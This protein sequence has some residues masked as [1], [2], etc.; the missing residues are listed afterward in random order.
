VLK[1]SD[2]KDIYQLSPLQKGMLFHYLHDEGQ[3]AYFEQ[4]DFTIEGHIDTACLEES[5]NLLIQKYDIFR[6]V[7]LY[8]K[9]NEPVQVVLKERKASVHFIDVSHMED[10]EA[11]IEQFKVKD[12]ET[13]FDLSSDLL[14]R[15][16]V[17]KTDSEQYH[18]IWSFHHILMDGWCLGIVL[19]DLFTMYQKK[20]HQEPVRLEAVTPY[21]EY[22]RWLGKQNTKLAQQYWADYLAGFDQLSDIPFREGKAQQYRYVQQELVY[23]LN[24]SVTSRLDQLAKK[25]Q[26]TLNTVFR[27]IWGI[28][29][30]RYN[31]STDAVFGTIVSGRPSEVRDVENIVGLFI[32]TIPVRVQCNPEEHFLQLLQKLQQASSESD[33]YSY[34]SL[35]DIQHGNSGAGGL[36]NHIVAFENYPLDTE[37]VEKKNELGF[38]IQDAHTFEQTNYDFN[39]LILPGKKLTF[40]IN[41]N[42]A[43]YSE[44]LVAHIYNHLEQLVNQILADPGRMIKDL[45]PLLMDERTQLLA[46]GSNPIDYPRDRTLHALFEEQAELRRDQ[47]A[48]MSQ[49][50]ELTYLELNQRANQ[51][52]HYL[53]RIGVRPG[54]LVGLSMERDLDLYVAILAILKAGGAYVPLDPINPADRLSFLFEDTQVAV[55]LTHQ[56]LANRLPCGE[57]QAVC[58]DAHRDRIIEEPITN[59]NLPGSGDDLAYVMYTSG[60]TGKP[61]GILTT[62]RNVVKVVRNNGYVEVGPEDKLL[63][64][65]NY[66]FDGSTFDIYAALLNG[67]KLVIVPKHVLLNLQELSDLIR[68]QQI[69]VSFMTTAFFNTLVDLD[70]SSLNSMRKILFGG[71]KVSVKHVKKAVEYLGE[72]RLIHVYGP[73][74]TT[75]FATSYSIDRTVLETNVVPI[76]APIGNTE[77]YVLNDEMQMVPIGVPGELYIGGDGLARA[78][79]NRPELTAERFVTNPFSKDRQERLYRTGDL[80]RYLPDGQIEFIDRLD[81]QVKIRGFRIELGEIE[82]VLS[83]HPVVK[84]VVVDVTEDKQLAAYLVGKEE[85]DIQTDEIRAYLS[86]Q[87]PDYMIPA[88]FIAMEKLPLNANGKIDR[89]A[90]PPLLSASTG[91]EYA[92]PTNPTEQTLVEI[93]EDILQVKPVGIHDHFFELG[94]HSLKA[95]LLASRVLKSLEIKLPIRVV[96]ARPTI[97]ELANY[98][99]GADKHV[100]PSIEPVREA[101]YYKVSSVQ[102]RLYTIQ[103]LDVNRTTYNMP[104]NF[105]MTGPLKVEKLTRAVE[106]I[107]NRHESLRTSFHMIDGELVQRI[108]PQV[109]PNIEYYKAED[110]EAASAVIHSFIRPFQLNMPSLCRFG[111]LEISAQEHVLMVDMHHIISDGSSISI[112][113]DE[114]TKLYKDESLP[115]LQLQY[116]DFA[117]WQNHLVQSEAYKQQERYWLD[118]FAGELPVLE[119]PTDYSRPLVQQFNGALFSYRVKPELM[120]Q[121]NMLNSKESTTLFM[122]LLA[123]YY[124]MLYKYT[125]QSDMVV[126]SSVAGRTQPE[127]ERVVGMFVNTIALR[128]CPQADQTFREFLG[129]V[130]DRIISSYEHTDFPFEDLIEKLEVKRDLSRN[131]LF[132]TL[133][134]VQNL[135]PA[136]LILPELTVT[137]EDVD[138]S[139][140]KVDLT[141]TITTGETLNIMLEYNTDLF[142]R[143]TI[144]RM[145]RHFEYILEQVL[146]APDLR[147]SDFELVTQVERE[148]LLVFGKN[149][150]DYPRDRTLHALFEEQAERAPDQ[151]ALMS[152]SGELTYHELNQRANQLAHYM[153]RIGV[154]AGDMVGLSMERDL[155]LY[156]GILAILKAGGA[157]VPLDPSYPAERLSYLFEDTQVAVLLTHQEL[158]DRLPCG[159]VQTV[160]L[161]AHHDRIA[162]EPVTNLNLPGSGDDLAY[163]MYTSGSTGKPKGILTMHRNVIKVVR[164]NGYVEVGPEDKVLQLSNYAFDGSTFDIYAALLNGA[165]LV[166]VPKHVLLNLQELSELIREQQITVTFMTTALF[167]TLVDLDVSSLNSFRKILI[168]GEKLSVR[169][170]KKAVE[171]LGEHRLINGYGPTETTVFA[172]SYSIDRT[173]LE[174]NVV[175]IGTPIGNT[176]T[177]VLNKQMQMVPIGVPGELYIGGDGLARSYYNRPELTAERFVTNPFSA[178]GQERL[179]RS[180]DLV[181]YMPDGRIEY[182]DRLDNQVKIRGFRIELGE[183]ETVLGG[184]PAVKDV[185][186]H[187]TEDK[188]LVAYLQVE[189]HQVNEASVPWR[190]YLLTRLPEYMVPSLFIIM[191]E[192]P[193]NANGKVDRKALP[194]TFDYEQEGTAYTAPVTEMEHTLADIW[195]ELL[196]RKS[197]GINDNFFDLGG[198]SIKGM[199]LIAKLYKEHLKLQMRDLYANPT[200]A[201]IIPHLSAITHHEEDM[202]EGKVPLTPIQRWLFDLMPEHIHDVNINITLSNDDGWKQEW[203]EQAISQ[204]VKHHDALRTIFKQEEGE[205]VQFIRGTIEG[206]YSIQSVDLRD[207]ADESA[208]M[209]EMI[210]E[211]SRHTNLYEGPLVKAT[212]FRMKSRDILVIS[213]HHLVMDDVSGNILTDDFIS[214][215]QQASTQKPIV[216]PPKTTSYKEWS[217]RLQQYAASEE[218][219]QE[220]P[221]WTQLQQAS[222]ISLPKDL[223]Q[224]EMMT[225]GDMEVEL[226]TLNAVETAKLFEITEQGV[227]AEPY[228]VLLTALGLTISTWSRQDHVFINLERHGREEIMEEANVS[229]TIGWFNAHSPVLLPMTTTDWQEAKHRVTEILR[230]VPNKG[231]GYSILKYLA[232]SKAS[233]LPCFKLQ[234][235]IS[236]NYHGRVDQSLGTQFKQSVHM[237]GNSF[238]DKFPVP[239]TLYINAIVLDGEL[240]FRFGY[241]RLMYKQQTIQS[242]SEQFKEQLMRNVITGVAR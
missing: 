190:Q 12:R 21:H 86:S 10:T 215:Y 193:L 238:S 37:A 154:S 232:P 103:L 128:A 187:V 5:F 78:Y 164:N 101:D 175:P 122:T 147:L 97:K 141:W 138:W 87:L 223:E 226:I 60:S 156:V 169:H 7:F 196:K 191:D 93:W 88:A 233:Q 125:G 85:G 27:A 148:E 36:F 170:V 229:R 81:S 194:R 228:E 195:Q 62:H 205:I 165:K 202:V 102:K 57:V 91:K 222:I 206:L 163:V 94:G 17:I 107:V 73:T 105:R 133:F 26:V 99:T 132:D 166:I 53:H 71:E 136:E 159:E 44:S 179:Y 153:R 13:G 33:Q 49:S 38:V 16:S 47:I 8:E 239:F 167:N 104:M 180:G 161:D 214:A 64:L 209:I 213:V 39:L 2:I 25:N 120:D 98:V 35:A 108:E 200:I 219:L 121:L 216:L 56:E 155:D 69:T 142:K 158:A 32:N 4:V 111:V 80:V 119:L 30:Q 207:E 79:Y 146:A 106:I 23:E 11:Y 112:I 217:E 54:D 197:I 234:P 9:M 114:L 100:L 83:Q 109:T 143:E 225:L 19:E 40:K 242:L 149:P 221:Y 31:N 152:Q 168:G 68:E 66:A 118:Q 82:T 76:G 50:G 90:L 224:T 182:L 201:G 162:D 135:D 237:I 181:R 28:M 123:A 29:L 140:S 72:H 15:L 174:T 220:V 75:V 96:F 92:A 124:T 150:I 24:E 212:I 65:S 117:A 22:I 58:L 134:V 192:F 55:L 43:V 208:R 48:L 77:T 51:L 189:T 130:K 145:V 227:Q 95:M 127:V 151:I 231:I 46:F 131:P 176:E 178:D 199:Q 188:Q 126:G 236:F 45:D 115:P 113:V 139:N 198:D 41:F 171:H 184:H 3:H 241:S 203:V 89:K 34:L 84:D 185:V 116:K 70:V 230:K 61:K 6:T 157:Y 186:V 59:L 137:Q 110:E 160:C 67:A 14:I 173:V 211:L 20:L 172:T 129:A 240:Q 144:E 177:Y 1:K 235:E 42:K 183:I 210:H 52:A 218:L 18:L 204:M 74:E 63:Q